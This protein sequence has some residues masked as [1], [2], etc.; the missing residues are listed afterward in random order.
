[1][2]LIDFDGLFD[3]KIAQFMKDS[4]KKR[5]QSAWE[6]L[7]P[8]LYEQFGDTYVAKIKCTPKQYY[9][10]MT[11][12]TLMRTLAAH[13]L[14]DVAVPRFLLGELEKREATDLLLQLLMEGNGALT[15][16][17]V[18][19]LGSEPRAFEYYFMLLQAADTEAE[20]K[21]RIAAILN[22]NA[23]EVKEQALAL[24]RQGQ[25]Q[26]IALELLSHVTDRDDEVYQILLDA[27]LDGE[28]W[29]LALRAGYLATYG[30]ER[31]LPAL[32]R[33]IEDES[34]GFVEFQQL[35]YAV[36][37]LG[38]EYEEERDFSADKDYL[39]VEAAKEKASEDK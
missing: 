29:Q 34:I 22:D 21:G 2:T 39:T 16:L 10:R 8:K 30:D 26:E 31:A 1:M 24:Y 15:S 23:D 25:E 6:D 35:K 28:E 36:E 17:A 27:F 3:E 33:K 32:Y 9:A 18:N 7:I 5:S 37:A 13:V 11:D 12:E 19:L 38:G 14:Q 4:K 20:V